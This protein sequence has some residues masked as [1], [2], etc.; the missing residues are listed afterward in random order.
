MP[1]PSRYRSLQASR[2]SLAGLA[3][4]ARYG[5]YAAGVAAF[6]DRVGPLLSDG[7]FTWGERRVLGVVALVTLGG[8]GLA[9]WAAGRAL[10]AASELVEV[11]TDTAEAAAETNRL[12]ETQVVPA[13]GRAALAMERLAAASA[14]A[15]MTTTAAA[16]PSAEEA[17]ARA[18]AAV[19][20]AVRQGRWGRAE[21]LLRDFRRGHPGASGEADALDAELAEARRAEADDLRARLDAALAGDDP[22]RVIASR[23]ALTQHLRG[24]ALDDLDRRVVRWLAGRVRDRAKAGPVTPGLADLAARVAD[25]FGDTAEGA[26]VLAALPGLRRRAGLCPRCARPH[27]ARDDSDACPDCQARPQPPQPRGASHGTHR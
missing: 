7:Q 19:R 13:L 11:F 8:F 20:Q 3:P 1:E 16:A 2:A 26:A 9:G 6:L 27:P 17:S 4:L 5:L 12:I 22:D 24:P 21:H 14:A 15:G 23:D 10:R 25:S 18:S